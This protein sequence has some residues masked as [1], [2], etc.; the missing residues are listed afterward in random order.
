MKNMK[1]GLKTGV[2]GRFIPIPLDVL[3]LDSI[4][5]FDLYI[6]SESSPAEAFRSHR[7]LFGRTGSTMAPVLYRQRDLP[8]TEETLGR[9]RENQVEFLYLD[10]TQES[11]YR[12][13][14]ER[15]LGALLADPHVDV[16]T[17]ATGL[18]ASVHGLLKDVLAHPMA[19]DVV[20]RSKTFAEQTVSFMLRERAALESLM[21]VMSTD[22]YTYTHS[23]NV[24]VFCVALAQRVGMDPPVMTRFALGA[25]LHD[26]GK[27][28]ID[29]SIIN[30][31]GK[32]SE[33]QWKVIK[34]HPVYGCEILETH[35]V[36]DEI[37]LDVTRHHHEKLTGAGYPD[38]LRG[39][40]ISQYVRCAT[41]SDIFDA[42][43]TKRAYKDALKSYPALKLIKEEMAA[44]LDPVLFQRFVL[45][46]GNRSA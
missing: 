32:L 37:V 5:D 36:N 42:L 25:L 20:V 21:R 28:K 29:P 17:K 38:G 9:L 33:E 4:V 26:I 15:N 19:E 44:E 8:F 31:K 7:E 27:S 6:Q 30:H 18:Y 39:G 12:R 14:V 35:K 1:A 46:V 22:Y 2:G 45:M 41:I 40:Q 23:V 34:M 43:T 10:A 3:R 16:Q 24:F 11:I 13:Y